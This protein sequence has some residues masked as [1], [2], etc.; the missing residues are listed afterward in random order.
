MFDQ[1]FRPNWIRDGM[2]NGSNCITTLSWWHVCTLCGIILVGGW[3][4]YVLCLYQCIWC[5]VLLFS[6]LQRVQWAGF[7]NCQNVHSIGWVLSAMF[8]EVRYNYATK[9]Q[10]MMTMMLM[11][12]N[13]IILENVWYR[14]KWSIIVLW[15]KRY[16]EYFEWNWYQFP[17]SHCRPYSRVIVPIS[18]TRNRD[19]LHRSSCNRTRF[20]AG[21]NNI[22]DEF[23]ISIIAPDLWSYT[24]SL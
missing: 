22:F 20:A 10:V 12:I 4:Q 11:L 3:M 17:G 8:I 6:K 18:I 19:Y 15:Y 13:N 2:Q 24:E 9:E 5:I 7:G 14:R 1:P 16:F 21:H 23:R